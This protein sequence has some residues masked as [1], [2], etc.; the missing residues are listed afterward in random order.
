MSTITKA[1]ETGRHRAE[2][3]AKAAK[4]SKPA[5]PAQP[6][7]PPGRRAQ[8]AQRAQRPLLRFVVLATLVVV[9]IASAVVAFFM[10]RSTSDTRALRSV[11]SARQDAVAAAMQDVPKILGYDYRHLSSDISGA[12]ALSTG[13]FLSDYSSTAQKVL[14]SAPSV[15]GIVTATVADQA[16]IK[17]QPDR[18]TL[19]LFVDHESVKQLKGQKTPTTR[20]DPFRVQVTMS[21]VHGRWLVSDLEGI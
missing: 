15:K 11:E 4:A 13:Q 14:A 10:H 12:K 3:P 8:R 6:T 18:V 2:K 5:E 9:T 1:P 19:L 20:I 21:K 7:P 17:A 16:V